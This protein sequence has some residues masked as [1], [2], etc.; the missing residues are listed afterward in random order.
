MENGGI[1]NLDRNS[2]T[3]ASSGLI[4]LISHIQNEIDKLKQQETQSNNKDGFLSQEN[5]FFS[6][7]N[8]LLSII[9]LWHNLFKTR[10]NYA[11]Y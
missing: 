2:A 8:L 5:D 9:Y 3:T 7:V 6:R 4:K 1:S 11:H 10:E